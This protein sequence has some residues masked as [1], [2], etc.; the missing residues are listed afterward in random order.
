[1]NENL[2]IKK[3][4]LE[5]DKIENQDIYPFNIEVVKNF[6]ELKLDTP[7]TFFIGENGIGKS[8]F[9]EAIAVSNALDKIK[10]VAN[11]II[12][13]NDEDAVASYIK[14]KVIK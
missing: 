8:T 5:K 4:V 10:N 14:K 13:T 7:V 6:T 3:I 2:M 12:G 11:E 9:I 1:M